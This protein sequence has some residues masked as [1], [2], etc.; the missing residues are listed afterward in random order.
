MNAA[1]ATTVEVRLVDRL[2]QEEEPGRDGRDPR[3]SLNPGSLEVL[4][5]RAEPSL[6]RPEPEVRF[7]FERLGYFWPD[8]VATRPDRPVFLRI[9]PLKDPWARQATD[10]G[11]GTAPAPS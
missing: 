11:R 3:S 9:L 10:A 1:D 2:F 8:P 6:G 7:Q 5:A 4:T